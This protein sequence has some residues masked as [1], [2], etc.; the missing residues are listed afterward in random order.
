MENPPEDH[1]QPILPDDDHE[2]VLAW[3]MPGNV[4]TRIWLTLV[5]VLINPSSSFER[6]GPPGYLQPYLLAL[7]PTS[8]L[9]I[10]MLIKDPIPELLEAQ[11]A[12][13][14]SVRINVGLAYF[15]FNNYNYVQWFN[16]LITPLN[17]AFTLLFT[18]GPLHL[19][20]RLFKFTG[21]AFYGHLQGC[22]L[23]RGRRL[24][25]ICFVLHSL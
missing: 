23:L 13:A 15:L 14:E 12:G 5:Q 11:K 7:I 22:D 20:L 2:P 8:I 3:E 19:F 10:F 6:L 4:F 1:Q 9:A 24:L 25:C 18:A 16:L 21:P 17:L